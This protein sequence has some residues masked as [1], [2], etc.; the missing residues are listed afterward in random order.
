M[1][2]ITHV[3]IPI[4]LCLGAYIG[5]YIASLLEQQASD[6]AD[7]PP[8]SCMALAS[9]SAKATPTS[10]STLEDGRALLGDAVILATGHD[11]RASSP[12]HADPW[13]SPSAAPISPDA[14]VLILGTG[15]TMVDYVLS[16]L[17]DGHRG[18]IIAMSLRGVLARPRRRVD[19]VP[20]AETEV[21]FGAGIN[22]LLRWLRD[23]IDRHIAEGGDWRGVIDGLRPYTQRLWR[24]L[25]PISKRRF[26]EHARLVGRASPSYGARTGG[27]DH[28]SHL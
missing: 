27:A 17:R 12:G 13:A 23:R 9:A 18:P 25:S 14:T 11:T 8:L 1:I 16:L 21:P 28:P 5:D 3:Q 22:R 15:L 10:W 7:A 2:I 4:A 26:L 20:I 6:R 19:A 24:E